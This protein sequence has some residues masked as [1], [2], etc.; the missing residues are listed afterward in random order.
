MN[1]H[2]LKPGE[3]IS[4]GRCPGTEAGEPIDW[5]V[6]AVDNEGRRA[7]VLSERILA[8]KPF[9]DKQT[10]VYWGECS[11]RGWLNREFLSEAF[12]ER[13]Q[14]QIVAPKPDSPVDA[15]IDAALWEIFDMEEDTLCIK[16]PIF[17]LSQDDIMKY[18]PDS[19]DAGCPGPCPKHP[20]GN[21]CRPC[22]WL[23]S[24]CTNTALAYTVEQGKN[25]GMSP[26]HPENRCG[27][28][29]AMWVKFV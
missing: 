17:L 22:C 18:I 4:L 27:V 26:I 7:L 15:S 20:S 21:Q 13:E 2:S 5:M 11:L 24:S 29:P 23:R 3:I 6:L 9:N 14:E 8:M 12:D 1:F 16:D 25:V 28:R 10:P 19:P